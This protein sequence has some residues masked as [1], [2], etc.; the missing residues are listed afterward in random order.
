MSDTKHTRFFCSTPECNVLK[1]HDGILI[2]CCV[3]IPV[4]RA[5]KLVV[6][7]KMMFLSASTE[8]H[9]TVLRHDDQIESEEELGHC[10][11]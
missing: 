2:V 7:S 8:A 4:T 10:D 6:K 3:H 9:L 1:L 5:T 11:I